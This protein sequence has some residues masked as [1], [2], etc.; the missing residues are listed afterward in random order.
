MALPSDPNPD[1]DR[2]PSD[3]PPQAQGVSGLEFMAA[4]PSDTAP[5][6]PFYAT[7]E[8]FVKDRP[9]H[10]FEDGAARAHANRASAHR[11][12][13]MDFSK[14]PLGQAGSTEAM[15]AT[16][17]KL[18]GRDPTALE[19]RNSRAFLDTISYSEGT[20]G[21][22]NNGYNMIVT[23]EDGSRFFD[24]YSKHPRLLVHVKPGLNS[25]A[26]GRYQ[27]LYR[28]D[29]DL[30]KEM[31]LHDF[32]PMAQDAK[33]LRLIQK[34]GALDDVMAGNFDAAVYE[35]RGTWASLPDAGY[36]QPERTLA[37][38][39]KIYAK[40]RDKLDGVSEAPVASNDD[41]K[42]RRQLPAYTSGR[43]VADLA[44]KDA[45][46]PDSRSRKDEA[47]TGAGL[48]PNYSATAAKIGAPVPGMGGPAFSGFLG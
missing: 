40:A 17:K 22:G 39:Q 29:Q 45:P 25:T 9:A 30:S 23:G 34:N 47:I 33:A 41:L 42:T 6:P 28:T 35:N 46:K 19:I 5:A 3:Q 44:T 16:L 27:F 1:S 38:L 37:S 26:A 10:F 7:E 2:Q 13:P 32:S 31:N 36:G 24:D 48:K 14:L 43:V 18:I 8:G 15:G 11:H 4:L 12:R 20:L 21:R